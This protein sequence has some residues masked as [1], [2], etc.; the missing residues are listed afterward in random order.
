MK[1]YIFTKSMKR[2]ERCNLCKKVYQELLYCS[3]FKKATS[4]LEKDIKAKKR[5]QLFRS[6]KQANIYAI[7]LITYKGLKIYFIMGSSLGFDIIFDSSPIDAG[8]VEYIRISATGVAVLYSQHVFDRYNER[9]CDGRFTTHKDM[10][11]QLFINN[12]KK[13]PLSRNEDDD[14]I[15]R[16][17]E[18]FLLGKVDKKHECFI[19]N[20]FYDNVE[21]KD[22]FEKDSARQSK[23]R[24]DELSKEQLK[25]YD[26]LGFKLQKG[27][28]TYEEFAYELKQ[29]GV[30]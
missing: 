28:L 7:D 6:K 24:L 11:K 30:I 19:F 27:K 9:A 5:K 20:T 15:Q 25:R 21:H 23:N 14:I 18:G 17:N 4:K 2:H 3:V 26:I 13:A 22:S 10:M 8:L 12:M 29:M 16:L 1:K